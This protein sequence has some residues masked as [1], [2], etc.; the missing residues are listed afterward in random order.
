MN[1]QSQASQDL[2]KRQLD[3]LEYAQEQPIPGTSQRSRGHSR[4]GAATAPHK[5][6]TSQNMFDY[7]SKRQNRLENDHRLSL[8]SEAKEFM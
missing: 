2:K 5:R 7:K 6:C 4:N 3:Y 1:R 8:S